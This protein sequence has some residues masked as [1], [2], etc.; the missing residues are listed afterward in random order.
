MDDDGLKVF[1]ALSYIEEDANDCR[2]VMGDNE[3][4]LHL[5]SN[6]TNVSKIASHRDARQL[7]R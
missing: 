7:Y 1:K 3:K 5:Q 2:I 4:L 6:R